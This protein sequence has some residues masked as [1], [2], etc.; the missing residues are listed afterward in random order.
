MTVSGHYTLFNKLKDLLFILRGIWLL[1]LFDLL[2]LFAFIKASQGAD[3]LLSVIEDLSDPAS[4]DFRIA[5][6]FWMLAGLAYWCISSEFCARFL[7]YLADN[8]GKSLAPERVNTRRNMQLH[9]SRASLYFP[10]LLFI[11]ALVKS[12]L[13]NNDGFLSL[14]V[15]L[16]FLVVLIL[17]LSLAT[18]MYC[19]YN[20]NWIVKAARKYDAIRWMAI[21]PRENKWVK[22]LYGIFN[23]VRIDIPQGNSSFNGKDLP[24]EVPL[25]NGVTLPRE[26]LAFDTNPTADAN[27]DIWMFKIPVLFYRCLLRQLLVLGLVSSSIIL[28]FAFVPS[29]RVY[30][31][32]G[33]TALVC[34]AFACWQVIYVVFAFLDKA[35]SVFP[36]RLTLI[37]LFIL[38]TFLNNDH[39]VREINNAA[40]TGIASDRRLPLTKHFQ[41]WFLHLVEDSLSR[42]AVYR[43]GSDG[44]KVPVIFIAAEG[45]ASRTG[46]FTAMV[47]SR[48]QDMYPS[49]GRYVY[50]YS[51]VSGGALGTNLFTALL[52]EQQH[53]KH[54]MNFTDAT[55]RFFKTDFLAPVT[56]KLVFG[57]IINY[58][59]PLNISSLDRAVI[60]ERSWEAGWYG[61]FDW[62]GINVLSDSF[63]QIVSDSFPAVF[64]NT[65]EVE[66]GLQCVWS[67]VA[68]SELPL[69]R[70]KDLYSRTGKNI[71]YS[72]A[73]DLSTRFP[74]ISPGA[75]ISYGK[76]NVRRHFVDGGYYENKGAETLMNVIRTLDI[77]TSRIKPYVIQFNFGVEDSTF[78]SVRSFNEISEVLGGIYNTR[79]GRAAVSQFHLRQLTEQLKGEFIPI[80]LELNTREF[81]MNWTL[82]NT[83]VSRL[84]DQITR[85]IL[86]Q[87]SLDRQ[88]QKELKKLFFIRKEANR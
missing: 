10:L 69:G 39:P 45:G 42:D 46:A 86:L 58:F 20:R 7:L 49:F 53:L 5:G 51:G 71:P 2:A 12:L 88:D 22:K 72:T 77:D 41:S 48:F 31:H 61:S 60:L 34:L 14:R 57:E 27:L 87:D 52:L 21:S 54:K 16:V 68:L 33:A 1:L 26:F 70:N 19:L 44:R 11:A 17:M 56:G 30:M 43:V 36:F 40:T 79:G 28:L 85:T 83:A 64:I 37:V 4:D 82:S 50:C 80:D 35:Q 78:K 18:L 29:P 23:D 24:R 13:Q 73:I 38:T 3:V 25:P 15:S 9:I 66:T 8:S 63:N 74:L 55:T 6:L 62:E 67:N 47:L 75:M 81:P 59:I 32:V 76:G 84:E 65:T